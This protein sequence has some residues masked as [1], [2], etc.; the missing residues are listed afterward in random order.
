[1][2]HLYIYMNDVQAGILTE[3]HPGSHYTFLYDEAYLNSPF[4][5]ISVT[6]PKRSD[7]YISE[8]LFPLFANMLPEGANRRVIC[9]NSRIDPKDFFGLLEAMADKDFVGAVHIK[10]KA[11]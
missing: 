1:M 10:S 5:A 11:E 9:R 3:Q 7:A 2:R 6:M 4:P 8:N